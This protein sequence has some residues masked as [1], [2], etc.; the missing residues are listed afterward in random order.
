[1]D[2]GRGGVLGR[3]GPRA[4]AVHLDLPLR[5]VFFSA[6]VGLVAAFVCL[7]KMKNSFLIIPDICHFCTPLHYLGLYKNTTKSA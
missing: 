2:F 3:Q 1:M 4:G 6:E 5:K 7:G